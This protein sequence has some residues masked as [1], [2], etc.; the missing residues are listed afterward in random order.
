MARY[1]YSS[2]PTASSHI[3]LLCLLPNTDRRAQIRCRIVDYDLSNLQSSHV[4]EALSY[5][6]GDPTD[7]RNINVD[8]AELPVT[9][10][11]EKAMHHLRDGFFQR[12]FWI[13]AICIN[14][15]DLK[16]R[17]AQ[18]KM[19]A[20]IYHNASRVV[21]WLGEEH[22]GSFEAMQ[23]LR[24]IANVQSD[25]LRGDN[26]GEILDISGKKR[27]QLLA[28]FQRPWFRRIW[29]LQEVAAAEVV[30]IKC[31]DVELSGQAFS[32]A[33]TSIGTLSRGWDCS[34]LIS[35]V[36]S[37][38]RLLSFTALV[39]DAPSG[40]TLNYHTLVKL[41]DIF[42]NHLA[43][44][45]RDK[46]YALIGMATWSDST[47]DVMPD[48]ELSWSQVFRNFITSI[49]SADEDAV[50]N[51]WDDAQVATLQTK[52]GLLGKIIRTHQGKD[53]QTINIATRSIF[54]RDLYWSILPRTLTYHVTQGIKTIREGDL[55]CIPRGASTPIIV[56]VS[57]SHLSIIAAG[58]PDPDF[59][60]IIENSM[61]SEHG[62]G[63]EDYAEWLASIEKEDKKLFLIWDW[64]ETSPEF[65]PPERICKLLDDE[66]KSLPTRKERYHSLLRLLQNQ[67][68][69]PMIVA[70]FEE[71]RRKKR[72]DAGLDPQFLKQVLDRVSSD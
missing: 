2:L 67:T 9:S 30:V 5:V 59:S 56:R 15:E 42:H 71:A 28:L 54:W 50:V 70:H 34:E 25:K 69:F 62:F 47:M 33:L 24:V 31:G 58:V 52:G 32:S 36:L 51:T 57:D 3:R 53:I 65:K 12:V 29:I 6:W 11:L 38:A 43:T 26:V 13:D 16:E 1:I 22:D 18:V 8:D 21:V 19:M 14:Q 17:A 55:L 23:M 39:S 61:A 45:P 48:Y 35:Q 66:R 40:I 64:H 63:K 4:Y 27:E 41:V 60:L 72:D 68:S 46:I 7:T 49:I 44:D 37:V 20:E 10:N